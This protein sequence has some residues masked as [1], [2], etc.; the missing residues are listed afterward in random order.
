MY[1]LS[2]T[3]RSRAPPPGDADE[4]AAM[5]DAAPPTAAEVRAAAEL[6]N[7]D[8]DAS[9]EDLKKAYKKAALRAHPDKGGTKEQFQAVADAYDVLVR[10]KEPKAARRPRGVPV[11]AEDLFSELFGAMMTQARGRV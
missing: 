4:R 8:P 7:V 9:P 6:L 5:D 2:A 10:N 3:S 1:N 11:N